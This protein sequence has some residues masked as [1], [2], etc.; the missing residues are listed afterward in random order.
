MP[1]HRPRLPD[2]TIADLRREYGDHTTF[3][4]MCAILDGDEI[5]LARSNRTLAETLMRYTISEGQIDDLGSQI[6]FG[7]IR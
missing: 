5:A 1:D 6:E 7:E 2:E 4:T 3:F